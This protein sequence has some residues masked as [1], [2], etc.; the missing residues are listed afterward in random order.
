MFAK[1][2]KYEWKASAPLLGTLGLAAL[3]I[4]LLGGLLLRLSDID[5]QSEVVESLLSAA[6]GMTLGFLCLALVAYVFATTLLLL[7]RFYQ[8]KFTDQGYLTFTLPVN[9][10]QIFLSSLLNLLLWQLI[11]IVFTALSVLLLVLVGD[12]L[13]DSQ[14]AYAQVQ[15]VFLEMME[16]TV[17]KQGILLWLSQIILSWL[18]S[19]VITLTCIVLGASWAKK[20]KLMT[21]F[22]IYY[23][24]SFIL[25]FITGILTAVVALASMQSENITL[26]MQNTTLCTAAV[27][28]VLMICGYFLSTHMMSRGLNLS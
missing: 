26:L 2:L 8:N 17:G 4:G 22:L 5:Y 28:L 1:L 23:G 19:G 16:N 7:H 14:T 10:H 21:A 3:G 9:S 24:I 11:S 20:H 13:P 25:Q 15:K 12:L 18:F 6:T 27:Q